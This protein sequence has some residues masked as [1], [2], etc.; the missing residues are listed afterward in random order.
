[1]ARVSGW[2]V[3]A[4]ATLALVACGDTIAHR[5][6]SGAPAGPSGGLVATNASL[7]DEPRLEPATFHSIG[8]RWPVRGD[9]NVNASIAVQ[10]LR[11]GDTQWKT[12]FPLF[13]TEPEGLSPENRIEGGWLFAGSVVDLDPGTDYAVALSLRDPDGGTTQR[14]LTQRTQAEPQEPV[15]MRTRYVV[16]AS[17]SGGG[18]GTGTVTNPFLGLRAAQA[19]AEPGDLF[20]LAAG[21]YA[22]GTWTVD[23]HGTAERPIIYRG[24]GPGETILD[25][26][27]AE[28]LVS[29][30][31]LRYVWFERLTFRHARF[32]VVGHS[33]SH[34]V[35]RRCR[36]EVT[37]AGIAAINGGYEESRGFVIMD[38]V[39]QGP[40]SW[41]RRRGIEDIDG[42]TITGAG[43]VVAYNRMSHLGDGIHGTE[44]GR[45]SASDIYNNDIEASTDDGIEAD[46]SDTNVR[47]F[48]NRITNVYTG[49]SAQ[50]INGGPLY[51]FRNAI[52]NAVYSPFKLHNDTSG[53]LIFHNTS[54]KAGIPFHINP[55]GETVTGVITRNNLFIGTSAPALVSTARMIGCDFDSDGY[56]W[57]WSR[58]VLA[59]LGGFAQW[60][61]AVYAS[62]AAAQRSGAL[63][64][65]RGAVVV[66]ET[67]NF[68]GQLEAPAD[69]DTQFSPPRVD[70]RLSPASRAVDAG[71]VLPNFNDGFT[72]AAPDLGC[73]ELGQ[74]LPH[75]GP[76]P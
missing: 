9:A 32:L 23:R 76:R 33:G 67:G 36:F 54:V 14:V 70:L 61:Q 63:Y 2:L 75:Y 17:A 48:R 41:P 65:Q 24:A 42:I 28:R 55:A 64:R 30:E 56:G 6:G 22:E 27:G 51:V 46:E 19:A 45:L 18:P 7:P 8:V 38:N 25:G 10:Y 44:H 66:P 58:G 68:V 12:A 57:P 69:S 5:P 73:C 74:P 34:F 72:G 4:G 31:G 13:R 21:T 62:P 29:A 47:V 43:H 11:R 20:L 15:G 50:P 49:V 53:V 35:I 39:F 40:T 1:V 52:Y 60:N 3:A 59:L 16:P 26:G 37:R 71:M